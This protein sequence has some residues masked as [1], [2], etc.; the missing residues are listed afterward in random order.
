MKKPLFDLP[1]FTDP[2]LV[3]DLGVWI[4]DG[5][6]EAFRFSWIERSGTGFIVMQQ[7]DPSS[8]TKIVGRY[9]YL[10]DAEKR[11]DQTYRKMKKGLSHGSYRR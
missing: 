6:A 9:S 2:V 11:L 1:R 4:S 5:K 7:G 3:H 10:S 8:A